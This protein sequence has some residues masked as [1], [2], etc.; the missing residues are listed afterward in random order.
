MKASAELRAAVAAAITPVDTEQI[1]DRYRTGD[2]PR[3]DRTKDVNV[4]Y[5]WDLYWHAQATAGP[6]HT[7]GLNS[8]HIDTMLRAIVAPL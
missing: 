7:V 1:R 8:A 6:F 2:Y 3:A 4:R 5:R